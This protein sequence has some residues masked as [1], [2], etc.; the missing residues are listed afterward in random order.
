M[1]G[2]IWV[3]AKDENDGYFVE[4]LKQTATTKRVK[5]GTTVYWQ[6]SS[7]WHQTIEE[8]EQWARDNGAVTIEH[9]DSSDL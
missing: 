8:C 4:L 3:T 1:I 2:K 9:F 7:S 6:E 5:P